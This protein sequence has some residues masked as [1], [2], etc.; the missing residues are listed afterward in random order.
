MGAEEIERAFNSEAGRDF[1]SETEVLL[2]T[3]SSS[4]DSES[5]LESMGVDTGFSIVI[6]GDLSF[7][8][9]ESAFT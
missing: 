4:G 6:D 3:I 2:D 9:P 1:R 8:R 5:H 7:C